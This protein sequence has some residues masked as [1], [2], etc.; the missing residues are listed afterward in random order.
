MESRYNPIVVRAWFVALVD[1]WFARCRRVGGLTG[2][3]MEAYSL[4]G[5]L[6]SAFLNGLVMPVFVWLGI[7]GVLFFF[8]S[9]IGDALK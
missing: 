1:G 6:L 2:A 4:Y 8:L 7:A 3:L 9:L 5:D